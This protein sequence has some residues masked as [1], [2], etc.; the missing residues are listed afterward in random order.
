MLLRLVR[1]NM[2]GRKWIDPLQFVFYRIII[3]TNIDMH[4]VRTNI[5]KTRVQHVSTVYRASGE[6]QYNATQGHCTAT[7]NLI[8]CQSDVAL[9][10]PDVFWN[11]PQP[12]IQHQEP[13]P[14]TVTHHS[15]YRNFCWQQT[16]PSRWPCSSARLPSL[17][18]LLPNLIQ[19]IP[20]C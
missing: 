5:G 2:A 11:P 3:Y 9:L 16:P 19:S 7:I 13:V 8:H 6:W 18:C 17:P 15:K 14:I 12:K 4:L 20:L 10:P 1:R